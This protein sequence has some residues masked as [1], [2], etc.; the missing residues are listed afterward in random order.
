M[1][2]INQVYELVGGRFVLIECNDN[3]KLISF[4]QRNGFERLQKDGEDGLVQMV[5]FL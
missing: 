3:T 4:Y 1:D 5:R 2:V